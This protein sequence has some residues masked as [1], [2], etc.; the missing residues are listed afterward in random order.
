MGRLSKAESA[1]NRVCATRTKR[2]KIKG[3]YLRSVTAE[4]EVYD[5]SLTIE[6]ERRSRRLSIPPT[7][8]NADFVKA[9]DEIHGQ[10]KAEIS[11]AGMPQMADILSR[12]TLERRLKP[13]T[14]LMMQAALKGFELDDKTNQLAMDGLLRSGYKA[15]TLKTKLKAIKGF[16]AWANSKYGLNLK[17]PVSGVTIPRGEAR[18]RIPTAEE[19]KDFV[20]YVA[21]FPDSDL[22]LL[23]LYIMIETGAR[24]STV[25]QIRPC[26]MD[27][28]WRLS[29]Y[30]VKKARRYSVKILITDKKIRKLWKK[31]IDRCV[32]NDTNLFTQ[33]H[34]GRLK[35]RMKR[36]FCRDENGERLSPHSFRHLKAT[37]LTRSGVP[38]KTASAILDCSD[39]VLLGV[40]TSVTQDDVDQA[41]MRE[42]S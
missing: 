5:V 35:A 18:H 20:A 13:N 24:C 10:I 9:V 1:K 36:F 14:A 12:Y 34:S 8:S 30:N 3:V 33:I 39:A 17:N 38:I 2:P 22:D 27:A 28:E 42:R 19:L 23:Y 32:S 25:E 21:H 31:C 15:G 40:Y 7:T 26:D 4:A 16:Y 41:F 29:L 6:S 11:R 37:N